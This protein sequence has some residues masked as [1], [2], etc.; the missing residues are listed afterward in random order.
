MRVIHFI[1]FTGEEYWSAVK[2][3]GSPHFIRR[4]WD[5]RALRDIGEEDLVIFAHRAGLE[6]PRTKTFNDIDER[7]LLPALK[8]AC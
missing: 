8:E 2:V 6:P 5:K 1:G 7:W 3:W 4:G